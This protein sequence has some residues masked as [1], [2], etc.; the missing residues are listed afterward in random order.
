MNA[1]HA[2]VTGGS[3]GIG[4]ELARQLAAAG[5]SLS[6]VA[7]GE[8]RLKQAAAEL[9]Q[10][11]TRSDQRVFVYAADVADVKQAEA[12][13]AAA[14]RELGVP[15]LVVTSAGI[16]IPGYF[17]DITLDNFER[18]MAVNY[19][20][21]LYIV[22]AAL[23]AMRARRQGRIVFVSSGAGLMGLFGYASYA[24][25]K[26]ALRG[27]AE[28]L[29][30]ELKAD[31][32]AVSIAY[33]PDTDTPMLAEENKTKPLETKLITG[34][35][36]TWSAPAV[37]SCI[38]RGIRRGKFAITPGLAITLMNR[39]PGIVLPVLSWYSDRLAASV[40][41]K[42]PRHEPGFNRPSALTQR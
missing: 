16:A 33:P 22:R 27:L 38:M 3:S 36:K 5:Y 26:F 20:G 17:E 8:D 23:P 19:F 41:G 2:L 1:L 15:D 4:L 7:R 32:V 34:V 37:A 29:R 25:G 28:G 21:S 12:A 14:T 40:R 24:P 35:V 18:S 10:R 30:A 13:V 6:L 42:R 31:G 9:A 11:F 39:M